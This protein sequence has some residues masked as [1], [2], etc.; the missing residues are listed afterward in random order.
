[1]F[2][3]LVSVAGH[4]Y[5]FGIDD[6]L[7]GPDAATKVPINL[8][9]DE[10]NELMGD[11]FIP[12]VNKGGGAGIQVTA[13]TQTLSDIE[14]RIGNKAKAGQ[15][16]GNFNNL[17]MLRVRET[18]TAELLTRQLPKVEVYTTTIVSGATDNSDRGRIDFTSQTQDRISMSS[19]PM[20]EPAHIV[21]L[22]KGQCFAFTQGGT[23]WKV[24]MPLPAPDPDEAMPK[25]LQQLAVY[26][27]QSYT[28]TGQ[29]WEHTGYP[30]IQEQPLPADLLDNGVTASDT[31][32]AADEDRP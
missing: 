26:M 18:A 20:I 24:R 23:L 10:F 14:A 25:D 27:R 7:P 3:D 15:V 29:W 5:K 6:G 12:M 17:F 2:S 13:Y 21:A 30:D 11:E 28:E 16:V 1:M 32:D 31:I 8:H 19:V 9:A 4:I 22:P